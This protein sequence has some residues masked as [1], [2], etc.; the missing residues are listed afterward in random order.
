MMKNEKKAADLA[1]IQRL[2]NAMIRESLLPTSWQWR[3]RHKKELV[4]EIRS[5]CPTDWLIQLNHR[6]QESKCYV[7]VR[8]EGAFTRFAIC[9]PIFIQNH[10]ELSLMEDLLS[11]IAWVREE[12]GLLISKSL[13]NELVNSRDNL[14]LAYQE[15][16][17]KR[18]WL[19]EMAQQYTKYND[20][21]VNIGDLL[22]WMKKEKGL[23]E[24]LY[25]ESLIIE[26]HPLHPGTKTKLG[27]SVQ[28]VQQYAPEF[29]QVV[30]LKLILI[31]KEQVE[32]TKAKGF[33]LHNAMFKWH[34]EVLSVMKSACTEKGKD[35]DDYQLFFVHPWQYQHVLPVLYRAERKGWIE[36]PYSLSS[37]AT[38]SFRTMALLDS[39]YHVKLP[40]RVQATSAVRTVS[41]GIT[42]NGPYL[43]HLF[44][45]VMA[46]EPELSKRMVMLPE[47]MG[48]YFRKDKDPDGT[49]GRNLS[50]IL[51]ENPQTFVQ[52]GEMAWVGA[53]LTAQNPLTGSPMI[54]DL[55]QQYVG[56]RAPVT[57]EH[58]LLYVDH[59]TEQF[60]TPLVYLL[61]KYG[62]A[63]EAHM[64]NSLVVTR[65]GRVE[66][67]IIRDLGGVRIDRKR[68]EKQLDLTACQFT[69]VFCEDMK[70]V[71]HLFFH[72]AI[73]NHLGDIIF[74]LS[75]YFQTPE[76]PFWNI[77]RKHVLQ[78]LDQTD[79]NVKKDQAELLQPVIQ[80]KSLLAMRMQAAAQDYIYTPL[81]NP[82]VIEEE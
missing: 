39:G 34:P 55:I 17:K 61:Q 44:N 4:E 81:K 53:S 67:F 45:Q 6:E 68:L 26:G 69:S 54:L 75:S 82:L 12:V 25:S 8:H 22:Q 15:K 76:Q 7:P 80:T 31:P 46:Q 3:K 40:V 60:L 62:V 2:F 29:A 52:D 38:L 47:W 35:L 72:S 24:C 63:L 37:K 50:F 10:G 20:D 16:T 36:V 51:R 32:V 71:Y 66:R 74:T 33:D 5:Q 43:S 9:L 49:Y 56:E 78:A 48:A 19:K 14:M 18:A 13:E 58:A 59:Y 30:P 41:P 42:V 21:Y 27:L 28:E 77:V 57:L 65:K 23:D 64:Q 11:F 73:Q 70:E 1:I 79:P